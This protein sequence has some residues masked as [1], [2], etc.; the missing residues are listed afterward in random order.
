[1]PLRAV[2]YNYLFPVADADGTQ[3]SEELGDISDLLRAAVPYLFADGPIP[4]LS[5]VND[6]LATGCSDLGM[7]GGAEWEPF[8]LS[9]AEFEA[10]VGYLDSP[11]GRRKFHIKK[12]V[13]V[14]SVPSEVRTTEDFSSWKIDEALK[15]PTHH[16]NS[17]ERK[18]VLNGKRVT[19]R[20]YW[21]DSKRQRR[22]RR[23][24]EP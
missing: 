3:S 4:P 9:D 17:P 20:E 5:V 7:S 15:D 22:E 1:M 16:L 18:G 2:K 24:E 11:A 19:F 12:A 14:A 21:E 6:L 23:G 13:I 10:F 8:A